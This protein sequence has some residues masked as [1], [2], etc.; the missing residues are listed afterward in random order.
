MIRCG[1]TRRV[2]V[3]RVWF[4]KS[5][6]GASMA[7]LLKHG[8]DP[9]VPSYL[10]SSDPKA[11]GSGEVPLHRLAAN[12]WDADVIRTFVGHGAQV[13]ASRADGRTPY[14]IAVRTGNVGVAQ[15]LLLLGAD[16][17]KLSVI[18]RL[19]GACA[20]GDGE[21]ARALAATRDSA[22]AAELAAWRVAMPADDH[23]VFLRACGDGR[24]ASVPLFAEQGW[25]LT[26][27]GPWGGTAL[28][29]AAWFGR[30]ACVRLLLDAGAPVNV[31]DATY[32]SSPIAWGA[33]GSLNSR[34]G[35]DDDYLAVIELLADA[36]STRAESIN[37]WDQVPES[38][39]SERVAA[40]VTRWAT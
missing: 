26:R 22:Q 21:Q 18:D 16:A 38:M 19:I 5:Y 12:G 28:H 31:R 25:S 33:H 8:A 32:G 30:P 6:C 27:E 7:W 10:D 29:W 2:S 3:E 1:V 15:V 36:G 24:A 4:A 11:M 20:I 17:S 9:N 37:Q 40:A 14:A 35:H 13:D 39:A 23:F 34:P